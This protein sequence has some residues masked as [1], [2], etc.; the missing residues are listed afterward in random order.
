MILE[1]ESL[2]EWS[3]SHDQYGRHAIK[4]LLLWNQKADDFESYYAVSG[5]QVL[6]SLLK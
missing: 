3:R 1:N 4:N 5:T 2:F 6:P